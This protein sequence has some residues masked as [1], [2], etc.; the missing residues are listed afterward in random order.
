[1]IDL[2]SST[3]PNVLKVILMLEETGLNYR[4]KPVNVWKG[5]QFDPAFVMLNPNSKVPVIVD[6]AGPGGAYTV[7]ESVAILVY[8]A[9]KTG[10]FLPASGRV[11]HD[12]MQWLIFQAANI[13]PAN[14]QFNHFERFAGPGNDY[15]MSRYTT[16]LKRLYDVLERRLGEKPYLGGD[17][18]SIADMASFPWVLVQ[19]RRLGESFAFLDRNSGQHPN[20]SAWLLR[21]EE[22]PGVQRALAVHA[23][24]TSAVATATSADLDRLFGRG[25]FAYRS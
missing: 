20:L 13:G 19:S 1:M 25:G 6:H 7:F 8:L 4:L 15:S 10:R 21:C 23:G 22:R 2:Y 5:E 16:E 14:G 3:T 24:M 12:V 17:D 18:Y 9:E 11:R